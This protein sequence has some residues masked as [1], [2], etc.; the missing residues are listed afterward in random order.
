MSQYLLEMPVGKTLYFLAR[1]EI[2]EQHERR[3]PESI[4]AHDP[5]AADFQ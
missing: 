1:H 3:L 2:D 5:D 4:E